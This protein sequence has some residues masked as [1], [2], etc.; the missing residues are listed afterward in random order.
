MYLLFVGLI[1]ILRYC[2]VRITCLTRRSL[3]AVLSLLPSLVGFG[4]ATSKSV[5]H[6]KLFVREDDR[7]VHFLPISS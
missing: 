5:P 2:Y 6:A 3:G 1:A 4:V 7:R